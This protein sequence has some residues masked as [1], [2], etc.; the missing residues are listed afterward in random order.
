MLISEYCLARFP[1]DIIMLDVPLGTTTREIFDETGL[2]KTDTITRPWRPRADAIIVTKDTLFVIEAKL[3]KILDGLSKLPF[4]ADL[5]DST[6]ELT[7]YKDLPRKMVLVS[8]SLPGWAVM[9]AT[10][11]EV[12]IEYYHPAWIHDYNEQIQNQWTAKARQA[13]A[14]RQAILKAHGFNDIAG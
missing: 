5:I 8:P 9:L 4:Y 11:H 3:M 12:V 1:S 13:S 7:A 6:P 10:H 2:I 14:A